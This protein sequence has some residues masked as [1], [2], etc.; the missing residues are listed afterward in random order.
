MDLLAKAK[1][2]NFFRR[3]REDESFSDLR[4]LLLSKW[5]ECKGGNEIGEL[6]YSDYK[7]FF[8]TGD[9][10]LYQK[11][12]FARRRTLTTSALLSLIYPENDEYFER[13]QDLI[14]AICDEFTWCL[15]AHI[16]ELNVNNACRIDLF[17]A[18]TA[19][20]LAEIYNIFYD[21]I[22]PF[23]RDRI[24]LELD[25]R[26]FTPFKLRCPEFKWE[27]GDANWTAVC[28]GSVACAY[29]LM[30]PDEAWEKLERFNASMD[31]FLDGFSSDGACLE[32]GSYWNYGMSFF[33]LYADMVREFTD[34]KVDYFKD[35]RAKR[36][37][38]FF[39]NYFLYEDKTIPFSDS[40]D[41]I[42]FS[43][44]IMC[45]VSRE[46]GSE[47]CV[48]SKKYRNYYLTRFSE[49]L[50]ELIWFD[51]SVP[52]QEKQSEREFF[53]ASAQWFIKRTTKFAFA[54]KGGH[55]GEPHNHN[56]IGSFV[57]LKDGEEILSDVGIGKYTRQYF[58]GERYTIFE[59]SSRSHCVPIIDGEHQKFG[60]E[61]SARDVN[62]REGVFSLDIAD[63]YG[64]CESEKILRSFS[65]DC[66]TV[67]LKDVFRLKS[68]RQIVERLVTKKEPKLD[69]PGCIT[70]GNA[71]LSYDFS[72]WRV[73]V[74]TELMTK[75]A[76]GKNGELIR[77]R[78]YLIDFTPVKDGVD[79]FSV[80][81]K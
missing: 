18:E 19:L 39:E 42:S 48:P 80:T 32:G 8:T 76:K 17:S 28:M 33:T 7:L 45:R 35:E 20:Y 44:G 60:R 24:P 43:L 36:I 74:D 81:V 53:A 73:S 41:K 37:Y 77:E 16:W 62:F 61:Y 23:V 4:T 14:Y 2:K 54:A 11:P 49:M 70:L 51:E 72:T 69:T 31:T 5:E 6:R 68:E 22:E 46:Y 50:R 10:D 21:R 65:F 9:R 30:K 47:I 12:Y 58:S 26:I 29:M 57:L 1:D 78:C 13:L 40:P 75:E 38:K 79:N 25:R 59:P 15:P 52:C 34:G 3:I 56:D 27:L 67:T 71:V 63:A 66:D 64:L 55:N